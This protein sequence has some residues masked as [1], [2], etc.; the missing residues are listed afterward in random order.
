[1]NAQMGILA[2]ASEVDLGRARS[3][4]L[5]GLGGPFAPKSSGSTKVSEPAPF[6]STVILNRATP[7]ASK[8]R[9]TKRAGAQPYIKPPMANSIF[10]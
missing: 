6:A 7:E 3:S 4:V 8:A 10:V 9:R 5:V 1:M 2:L